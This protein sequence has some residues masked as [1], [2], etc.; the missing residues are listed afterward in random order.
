ML[1]LLA[2][3]SLSLLLIPTEPC[4][5]GSGTLGT[6]ATFEYEM[7]PPIS[8]TYFSASPY[9][10]QIDETFANY[11][12][13]SDVQNSINEVLQSNSIPTNDVNPPTV[14]YTAPE[15]QISSAPNCTLDIA[16]QTLTANG[17]VTHLC[18][19]VDGKATAELFL[20]PLVVQI[21]AVSAIYQSQWTALASQV[22]DKL[23]T[24]RSAEFYTD[25]I[26]VVSN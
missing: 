19:D 20:R 24:R 14:Q 3:F 17:R 8:Y 1:N 13:K 2:V 21:T 7:F 26:V 9:P 22:A 10:G 15:A 25:P 11:E 12:V 16:N 5:P 6:K 18:K 23:R 4:A